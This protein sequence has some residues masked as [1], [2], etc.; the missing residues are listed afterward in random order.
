VGMPDLVL[1]E[2]ACAYVI[3]KPGARLDVPELVGFLRA[4]RIAAYKLPERLEVVA[5]FPLTGVGK[6][7][8]QAL[9]DDVAEKLAVAA[10]P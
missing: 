9:R 4:K 8:K 6:V 10:R 1:G 7:A 5:R 2:R 3:L